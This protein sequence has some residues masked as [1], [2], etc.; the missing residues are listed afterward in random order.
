[1]RHED[2]LE[3]GGSRDRAELEARLIRTA[4]QLGFDLMSSFLVIE[5]P[6]ARPLFEIVENTPAGYIEVSRDF[7]LG[8]RCPVMQHV[9]RSHRPIVYDRATYLRAGAIDLWEV[10]APFG[11][12][13]GVVLALHLPEGRHLVLGVDRD[14]DVPMDEAERL[15]LLGTLHLLAVHTVEPALK[16]LGGV[17]A[18]DR[19]PPHLTR[20]E[21]EILRWTA[22]G[23]STWVIG[24]IMSLSESTVNF[25]LRN[26]MC[27]LKCNSK[28]VAAHRAS[29]LGLI[30][31]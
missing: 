15:R 25:H 29:T 12:K 20:R 19:E 21:Q 10:Q 18:T 17:A 22:S 26:A 8:L 23:K 1:M 3:I 6:G 2:L 28:H 30:S 4:F 24:K 11:Y 14:Q 13:A 27:K 31:I 5:R 7:E 16:F 9:K